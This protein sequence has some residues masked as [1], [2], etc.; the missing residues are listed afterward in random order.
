MASQG[1]RRERHEHEHLYQPLDPARKEIRLL[2]FHED[3]PIAVSDQPLACNMT[4][5]SLSGVDRPPY[6]A[7]SYTWGDSSL[8]RKITV[9]GLQFWAPQNAEVA[10]RNLHSKV[11]CDKPIR[12]WIDSICINQESK[13]ERSQQV[14]IMGN[15][16]FYAHEVLVW[17]RP[18]DGTTAEAV[19]SFELIMAQCRAETDNLTKFHEVMYLKVG[20]GGYYNP[21]GSSSLP[22]DIHRAS[23]KSFFSCPWFNRLWA[24]FL[25]YNPPQDITTIMA[26][27]LK[28]YMGYL[29][30]L[31]QWSK[32]QHYA[33]NTSATEVRMPLIGWMFW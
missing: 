2:E 30:S 25:I 27:C 14:T 17:L 13:A 21:F 32:R 20:L 26:E 9:N 7:V 19:R 15:I 31:G 33:V 28:H 24:K 12:L 23:L 11:S 22:E 29:L 10:L 3:F 8:R 5:F 4:V 6:Y 18:D 1:S 16:Y